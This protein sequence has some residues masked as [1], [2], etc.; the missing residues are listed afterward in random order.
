MRH[1]AIDPYV[2]DSSLLERADNK[3]ATWSQVLERCAPA[4]N[5]ADFATSRNALTNRS[6]SSLRMYT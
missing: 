5:Q 2:I 1:A 3:R 4:A 6:S